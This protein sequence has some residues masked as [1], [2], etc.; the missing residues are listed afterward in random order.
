[1]ASCS[2]YSWWM[3]SCWE[4]FN[5]CSCPWEWASHHEFL[6]SHMGI[7]R[8]SGTCHHNWSKIL[9]LG[10]S[11]WTR[12]LC[13]SWCSLLLPW[14]DQPKRF[15]HELPYGHGN[16]IPSLPDR[17]CSKR[18]YMVLGC[19]PFPPY[20]HSKQ[21]L[22]LLPSPL[23]GSENLENFVRPPWELASLKGHGC[24]LEGGWIGD[25]KLLRDGL[26]K[27]GIK[28]AFTLSSPKPIYYG[29]PMC[30]NNLC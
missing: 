8:W 17:T 4:P 3:V 16:E 15:L 25:I 20:W 2:S 7:R 29:S 30:T 23:H 5:L 10:P 19:P 12:L 13:S 6:Y 18:F 24:R 28:I 22:H 21:D 14:M 26:N 11:S 27:C 9:I 1:M